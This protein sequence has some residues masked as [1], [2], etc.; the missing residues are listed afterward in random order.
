MCN[1]FNF[2][3]LK[4][5]TGITALM[6]IIY[7][8]EFVS[9]QHFLIKYNLRIVSNQLTEPKTNT[10]SNWVTVLTKLYNSEHFCKIIKE[11]TSAKL[12]NQIG[13]KFK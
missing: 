11:G 12:P 6:I 5:I 13:K 7:K 2:F 8:K 3:A 9:M 4:K 10:C 1:F